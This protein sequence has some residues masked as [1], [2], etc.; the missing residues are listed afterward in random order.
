MFTIQK[1]MQYNT[2]ANQKTVEILAS[3]D[4]NT[5]DTEMK[6]SFPTIRKT[7]MHVWD[8][9]QIW[10]LRLQGQPTT[11]WASQDFAG[12]TEE[13]YKA[14]IHDSQAFADFIAGKDHAYLDGEIVYKNMKGVEFKNGVEGILFHVVNHGTFHRGQI[15]TML[16]ELGFTSFPSQD[17]ITFLREV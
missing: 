4:D 15:L 11:K 3:V 9:Q 1:F 13:L 12:S 2:W 10:L 14:F 7:L 8:A 17:L 6:S 16:R 5:L